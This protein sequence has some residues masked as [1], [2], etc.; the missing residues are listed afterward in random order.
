MQKSSIQLLISP[1]AHGG[2]ATGVWDDE[3]TVIHSVDPSSANR[4]PIGMRGSSDTCFPESKAAHADRSRYVSEEW[5]DLH[6][7]SFKYIPVALYP[8]FLHLLPI[9]DLWPCSVE[10]KMG[11]IDGVGVRGGGGCHM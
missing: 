11:V 4:N 7:C 8:C 10:A 3:S 1:N 5:T 9:G 6:K 2:L